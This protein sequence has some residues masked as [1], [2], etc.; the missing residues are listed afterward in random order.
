MKLIPASS[1]A[2]MMRIDSS[3]S[4]FPQSPNIIAPRQSGLTL[5]PMLP[6]L[7]SCMAPHL[8]DGR[9]AGFESVARRPQVQTPDAD[10]LGTRQSRRL[11]EVV[12][13]PPCPVAERLRVVV[14]ESLHVLDLE[15]GALERKLDARQRQ[16][17]AVGEDVTLRERPGFRGL[18]IEA[19]DAV[20]KQPSAAGQHAPELLC[21]D[22]DLRLPDVL[23][24]ADAGDRIEL[25]AL[26]LTVVLD[27]DVDLLGQAGS[28]R[29]FARHARLRLRQRDAGDVDVVLLGGVQDPAAPAAAHVEHTLARL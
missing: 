22:V 7:R 13:E 5:T 2:W 11:L 21:V 6:R 18:R 28:F 10:A 26:Q 8:V 24:H 14:A 19:R 16:W 3:W 17:V 23:D 15:P 4:V 12:V 1:A 9:E 25:L 20:V 29:S 27:A